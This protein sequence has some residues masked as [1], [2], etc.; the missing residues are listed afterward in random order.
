METSKK[1]NDLL[2]EHLSPDQFEINPPSLEALQR[3]RSR[4]MMHKTIA[5]ERPDVFVFIASFLNLKIKLYHAVIALLLI[6]AAVLFL[7]KKPIPF[8][9][10]L[11]SS[12]Q[13]SS[14]AAVRNST[15]L[16]CIQTFVSP[17]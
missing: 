16:S 10:E 12:T 3:A 11:S 4:V 17:K 6:Y 14:L 9:Q 13:A 8:R 7:N 1:I 5:M 2:K 15:V